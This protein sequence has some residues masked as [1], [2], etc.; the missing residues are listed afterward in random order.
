VTRNFTHRLATRDKTPLLVGIVGSSSSGKTYSALRLATGFQR[1]NPGPIFV[2]DTEAGRAKQYAKNKAGV[3][4]VFEHVPFGAPFGPLDYL[5]VIK[6]CID[7]GAT[8]IVIDS[9]SHEHEGAGGL[10]EMHA[11]EHKRMGGKQSTSGFAWTKPKSEHRRLINTIL[12]FNCNFIFCFRARQK[13]D[14]NKKDAQ[15]K[16]MDPEPL[17][18]MPVGDETWMYEFTMQALLYPG[19]RGVPTWKSDMPG[20]KEHVIKLP[21]FFESAFAS[22]PQLSEDVGEAL[23]KWAIGDAPTETLTAAQLIA[24]FAACSEPSEYR[25]LGDVTKA[26]WAAISKD[27]RPRVTAASKQCAQKI[28]DAAKAKD[29]TPTPDDEFEPTAVAG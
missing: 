23:A 11:E 17:G 20:E 12:Q 15:G 29:S 2:I 9:M 13:L 7:N 22:N 24:E 26:S 18:F 1:V 27:D 21:G 19:S 8:N 4:F 16:R 3:G 25:R 6:Y 10:L 5:D 28:E 14:W